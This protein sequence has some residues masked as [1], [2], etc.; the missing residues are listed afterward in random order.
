[1]KNL[2]TILAIFATLFAS[3][4][5]HTDSTAACCS[6][7]KFTPYV[8]FGVSMTNV[9]QE[10][11]KPRQ[12]W[13]N[14]SYFGFEAGVTHKNLGLGLV[15][16]RGSFS[17]IDK[18]FSG[19]N[20]GSDLRGNYFAEVKSTVTQP[21]GNVNVTALFGY[22]TYFTSDRTFIEYGVGMSYS[23]NKFAYG[24]SYS[25][26]DGVNFVTPNITYNF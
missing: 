12:D 7:P 10:M 24:M 22:G 8:S 6:K 11:D 14:T 5:C 18:D 13:Y 9:K 23:V 15:L 3:A 2:F 25:N 17:G 20:K 1:M 19:V 21:V 16:G 4:Q 26:W